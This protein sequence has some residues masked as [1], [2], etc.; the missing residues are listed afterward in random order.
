[1]DDLCPT[2]SNLRSQIFSWVKAA[3]SSIESEFIRRALLECMMK[4]DEFPDRSNSLRWGRI[5]PKGYM[6]VP[7]QIRNSSKFGHDEGWLSH[8]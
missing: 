7:I 6:K 8:C 3:K 5:F 2:P 1:M 4:D